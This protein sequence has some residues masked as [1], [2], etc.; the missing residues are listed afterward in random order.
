MI[1]IS[2]YASN[3]RK[4]LKL[5]PLGDVRLVDYVHIVGETDEGYLII[6]NE[7]RGIKEG[8]A[9]VTKAFLWKFYLMQEELEKL[10]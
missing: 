1:S 4:Q 9:I 5:I 3:C 7:N 6:K 10:K 8:H 2:L